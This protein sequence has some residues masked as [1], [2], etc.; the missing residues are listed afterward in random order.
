M[1]S[2]S[3]SSAQCTSSN[4]SSSGCRSARCSTSIRTVN[5]RW[6]AS[7]GRWSTPSPRTTLR[8]RVAS[9]A[10]TAGKAPRR[11]RRPSRVRRPPDRSRRRPAMLRSISAAARYGRR[12]LVGETPAPDRSAAVAPDPLGELR[13]RASSCRCRRGR[14]PSR[15]EGARPR[16]RAPTPSR[17][18]RARVRGR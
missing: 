16:P 8:Y 12:L 9:P 3:V 6:I 10:S 5:R 7:S 13:A 15:G 4:T 11:A 2:S 14:G 18:V 17:A 1:S